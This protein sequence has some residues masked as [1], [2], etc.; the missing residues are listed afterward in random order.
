[1]SS[2]APSPT[3]VL[4]VFDTFGPPGTPLTTTEVAEKFNC[5]DRTIYNKLDAL[6]NDGL[7]KTKKVGA[8]GRVWWQPP[9]DPEQQ[10]NCKLN[11]DWITETPSYVDESLIA[12]QSGSEMAKRIRKKD[13]SE[14]ALGSMDDWPQ[15]LQIAVNIML[16]ANEAIGIYWGS[17]HTLLYNDAWRELIGDKHPDAL[18]QPAREVFPEIWGSIEPMF[19]HVMDEKGVVK[20]QEKRLSL[21]RGEEMENAWFDYSFNPIP[22]AD[23]SIGGVFNI[24]I[25]VT[26][27]KKVEKEL[28]EA[29]EQLEVATT[30]G[31]VGI[32][33][34]DL[35]TD[36]VTADTTVAE[37]FGIDP[38][39]AAAGTPIDDYIAS[40]HQDDQDQM[41]QA[42]ETAVNETD[43]FESE[44]RALD[45]NGNERWVLARGEV[46]YDEN[47]NQ[48]RM[49]GA[50]LDITERKHREEERRKQAELD[51][52]RVTLVDNLRPI[53]DPAEMQHEAARIIGE[54]LDIDRALYGEVLAD[55]NTNL[56][57]ADYYRGDVPSLVGEHHLHE[58]GQYITEG[59]QAGETLVI[60]DFS[61]VSELSDEE[62][63]RY[64]QMDICAWIGV[65]LIKDGRLTAYFI[66]NQSTPREW[67]D[68][69]IAMIEET[70]ERTWAAVQRTQ[71]EQALQESE[72]RLQQTN[73]SL[74]RL[75]AASQELINADME[76]ISDRAA[77]LVLD[78]LNV[79]CAAL[80]R[81]DETTGD[82][83]ENAC[84]T[85]SE[86]DPAAIR[87]PDQFS[88]QVWQTFLGDDLDI[89]NDLTTPENASSG[90][91][92]RSRVLVPLGR[93][94]VI[95]AGSTRT[96]TFDEQTI[97][98]IETI[99]ATVKTAWDRAEGEQ[100][101]NRQN[102][103]LERLDQLNTLIRQID[104]ALVRADT[105]TEIDQS[106]CKRLADS[107]LFEFA[108]IGEFDAIRETIEPRQWAG[109]NSSIVEDRTITI[110]DSATNQN[111]VAATASTR[112]TQV[113][114]DIA[115]DRRIGSCRGAILEEGARSCISIPL[116]YKETL[117]GI[118]SVYIGQPQPNE[119][120]QHILDEL[121]RTIAHAIHAAQKQETTQTDSVVELTLQFQEPA[122]VLARLARDADVQLQFKGIVPSEN[123]SSHVFF[124]G[125]QASVDEIQNTG[126][127]LSGISALTCVAE[128]DESCMYKGPCLIARQHRIKS[129]E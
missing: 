19:E 31:S 60:N 32:W 93:H 92:L 26:E 99:A 66:V 86:I 80:W 12:L 79:E 46:E 18:G 87:L 124:T 95:C 100:E 121:G 35:E 11:L 28:R 1:M 73:A 48:I 113:V 38:E 128:H 25:E 103:E 24:A 59:F 68:T 129:L 63:T 5:T 43:E 112:D 49:N 62:R 119:R 88:E 97:G 65:P 41:Q 118:L 70:A 53:A 58:Y 50:L 42:L 34:W 75:N 23:G 74:E 98:L 89:D 122:T 4:E 64:L 116:L 76:A 84:H 33:V 106:V 51:A 102:Q 2:S 14:T 54:Q 123:G 29:K 120:N 30:A 13:W 83:Q 39:T 6:V 20:E 40:I 111:P 61:T 8:R 117:Y 126:T 101:L 37:T 107:D 17:E 115:T 15:Q 127:N 77:D 3:T 7:L 9:R 69:E 27:R 94:G 85:N 44:Y 45:M 21:D 90:S 109:I 16:S 47:G 110:D 67:T 105:V 104:Q 78:I 52:F 56:I 81:Y 57:H 55:G 91:L 114:A 108:W 22:V 71:A 36:L 10:A 82:L 125:D 72:K 96:G